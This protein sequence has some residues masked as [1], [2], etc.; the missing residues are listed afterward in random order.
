MR[1]EGRHSDNTPN[2]SLTRTVERVYDLEFSSLFHHLFRENNL[3][4]SNSM[5]FINHMLYRCS[6]WSS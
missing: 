1:V 4:D 5:H 2:L 6:K 3:M